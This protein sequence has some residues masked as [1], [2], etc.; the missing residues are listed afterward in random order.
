MHVDHELRIHTFRRL[1]E[2][3]FKGTFKAPGPKLKLRDFFD[4]FAGG[5]ASFFAS[6]GANRPS[7]MFSFP[8]SEAI[9]QF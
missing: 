1:P 2:S 7:V 3:S 9:V 8:A 5:D 6:D 4:G